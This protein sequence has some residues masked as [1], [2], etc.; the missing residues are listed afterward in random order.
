MS[1][2]N[3][4]RTAFTLVEL[5]VVVSIISVLAGLILPATQNAREAARRMT[6]SSHLRQIGLA[7]HSYD[8]IHEK[9]PPTIL[10]SGA[11]GWVSLLPYIEQS[12]IF[13]EWDFNKRLDAEPNVIL[14][15]QT[16]EV[17][18]CPSMILPDQNGV[19]EGY[20]SYAFSTGSEYYR[21]ALNNGAMIDYFNQLY[22]ER[23]EEQSPISLN[24][25]SVLDGTSNTIMAGEL[26][27]GI[28]DLLP[29]GGFTKWAE[30]YPYHSAASMAGSFNAKEGKFD[31]RSWETFRGPHPGIVNFVLSDGSVDGIS[32]DTDAMVLDQIASRDDGQVVAWR[33]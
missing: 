12:G 30:G 11:S 15:K 6:C 23:G 27:F 29:N 31:F 22:W 16:P 1:T 4:H 10:P 24:D 8:S 14:K 33:D 5:L 26:G 20:S 17:W 19:A 25:L 2:T 7:I 21:R 9:L 3:S 18:K 28:R 13:N 32:E